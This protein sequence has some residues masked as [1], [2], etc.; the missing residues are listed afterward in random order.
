MRKI[1]SLNQAIKA[2]Q[3]NKFINKF[4]AQIK[5]NQ[6]RDKKTAKQVFIPFGLSVL[7][8]AI[9]LNIIPLV[10]GTT[11]VGALAIIKMVKED[12]EYETKRRKKLYQM[13]N[14]KII[15]LSEEDDS[16]Y[17]CF[18][19]KSITRSHES[20][21]SE[22]LNEML[23]A[24]KKT[25]LTLLNQ[26]KV[27]NVVN[28]DLSKATTETEDKI[29]NYN[30]A[31][32]A[33]ADDYRLYARA[34]TLPPL[35]INN[36]EWE[37]FFYTIYKRFEEVEIEDKFYEFMSLL[38]RYTFADALVSNSKEITINSYLNQ[39]M[40]L[41]S[42]GLKDLNIESVIEEIKS[43]LCQSEVIDFIGFQKRKINNQ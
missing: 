13:Q 38:Q 14:P 11:Y 3:I 9:T 5:K 32:E 42:H 2:I 8:S 15:T 36:R 4:E 21:F 23:D 28:D 20:Y 35:K 16:E 41:E 43:K 22:E 6:A 33:L 18:N 1:V 17:A 31:L 27:E 19:D 26:G 7:L 24:P 40:K 37:S 34:Y 12:M 29:E 10:L 25:K 39:L 30:D